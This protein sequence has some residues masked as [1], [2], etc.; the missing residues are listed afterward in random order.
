MGSRGHCDGIE[1]AD[2]RRAGKDEKATLFEARR[3]RGRNS[4]LYPRT[5]IL[6][7]SCREE[8]KKGDS[9]ETTWDNVEEW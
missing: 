7:S 4:L 6:E 3:L 8:R 1:E 9:K 2:A 5:R